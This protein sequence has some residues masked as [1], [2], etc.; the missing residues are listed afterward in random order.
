MKNKK[1]EEIKENISFSKLSLILFGAA[2]A[3]ILIGYVLLS[4]G[5]IA[6]SPVLL[7]LGYVVLIPLAILKK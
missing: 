5:D 4:R 7:V 3:S 1:N 2:I 6:F